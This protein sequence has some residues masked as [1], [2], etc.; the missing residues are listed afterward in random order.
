MMFSIFWDFFKNL[1]L[2]K[3]ALFVLLIEQRHHKWATAPNGPSFKL[4]MVRLTT[5]N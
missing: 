2:S 4:A 1:A 3:L 5:A